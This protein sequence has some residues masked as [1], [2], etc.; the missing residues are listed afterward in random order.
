MKH[1][2]DISK[3]SFVV[4]EVIIGG[5]GG[6]LLQSASTYNVMHMYVYHEINII[7][8]NI[9]R[10]VCTSPHIHKQYM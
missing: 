4:V 8:F 3:K 7:T 9:V 1:F 10:C 5:G 2:Y 6:E